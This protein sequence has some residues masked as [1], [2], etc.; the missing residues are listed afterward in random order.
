MDNSSALSEASTEAIRHNPREE[1][2][3]LILIN[4][5][6]HLPDIS[7]MLWRPAPTSRRN[8]LSG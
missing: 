3:A 2:E 4:Q 6:G 5:G 1:I 8:E 7:F